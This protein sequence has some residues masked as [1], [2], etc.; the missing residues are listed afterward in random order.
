MD[1]LA[2]LLLRL[3]QDRAGAVHVDQCPGCGGLFLDR[4]E[5]VST[6]GRN[7][8][9]T[10]RHNARTGAL[11]F[12]VQGSGDVGRGLALDVAFT[13]ELAR[14]RVVSSERLLLVFNLRSGVLRT[15]AVGV[16]PAFPGRSAGPLLL[17]GEL[18][19][20]QE[21]GGRTLALRGQETLGPISLM[22]K[23]RASEATMLHLVHDVTSAGQ[24]VY[25]GEGKQYLDFFGGI[26]TVS[27]GHAIPEINEPIKEQLDRIIHSSTLFLIRSQIELAERLRMMTPL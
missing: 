18:K 9:D 7:P 20:M 16:W 4:G 25:D 23:G 14:R 13:R 11:I 27:S 2:R 21:S 15:I 3:V 5:I 17:S 19:I 10:Q 22:V 12:G 26:A 1:D 6:R 8:D 24:F